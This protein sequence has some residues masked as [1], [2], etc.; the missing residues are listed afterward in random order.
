VFAVVA[1]N[2]SRLLAQTDSSIPLQYKPPPI[3]STLNTYEQILRIKQQKLAIE[4]QERAAERERVM[5]REHAERPVAKEKNTEPAGQ[6]PQGLAPLLT[7]GSFNGRGWNAFSPDAK[8]VYIWAA[9]DA[10]SRENPTAGAKYVAGTLTFT[11]TA[12]AIDRCY[13]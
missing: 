7:Y 9:G 13:S 3:N 4:E 10:L 2:G 5:R 8:V 11:E 12:N 1:V 6:T